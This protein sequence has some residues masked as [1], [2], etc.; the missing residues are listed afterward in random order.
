LNENSYQ[1]EALLSRDAMA[2][3]VYR[4]VVMRDN[5]ALI[6]SIVPPPSAQ[7]APDTAGGEVGSEV[8]DAALVAVAA[9]APAVNLERNWSSGCGRPTPAPL[10]RLTVAGRERQLITVMPEEYHANRPHRLVFAFHGRTNANHQVRRYYEVEGV[11]EDAIIIY[12]Q[13]LPRGN[14]YSWSDAG[15]RASA[16]RDYAFFDAMSEYFSANYCLDL[17]QVYALGHSLGGWFSS[18]L[19]C[20]RGEQLRAVASLGGSI[21]VSECR[22]NVAAM[23]IHN[24]NDRLVPFA[25]GEAT[26]DLFLTQNN[27]NL[28]AQASTPQ[29]LACQQYGSGDYPV[30]WCPHRNDY[31]YNGRYYPHNWPDGAGR[32]ML[33]F[34]SSLP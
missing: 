7:L 33:E 6:A 28:Q 15:D 5:A 34:F 9:P 16:L 23:V 26:R 14:G 29:L 25:Q 4:A 18:S 10:S 32:A 27:L 11:W 12:P 2:Q 20:A 30:K 3:L 13:G 17:D 22:G 21:S 24:P 1:P 19:G 8:D 31:S